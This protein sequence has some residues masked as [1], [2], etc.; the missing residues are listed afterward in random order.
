MD[1]Y[2][3][4]GVAYDASDVEIKSK[5]RI[6]SRKYHPDANVGNPNQKAYEE[7]FKEVQQAYNMIMDERQGKNVSGAYNYRNYGYSTYTENEQK[8]ESQDDMYLRSAAS[9]INNGYYREGINV[10]SNVKNRDGRWYYLSAW[11]NYYIGNISTAQEHAAQS[12]KFEPDNLLYRDLFNDIMSGESRYQSMSGRYGGNPTSM[13]YIGSRV[14]TCCS[15]ALLCS[16]LAAPCSGLGMPV[17]C[18]I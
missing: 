5:Y 6:L 7:K 1:P 8:T 13:D 10:L 9:Y 15:R 4:L 18:C 12:L 2:K 3:V 11:A 16:C 14:L 17:F